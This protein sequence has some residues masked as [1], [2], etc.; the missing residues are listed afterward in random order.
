MVHAQTSSSVSRISDAKFWDDCRPLWSDITT[1][2]IN[3]AIILQH[4]EK[5]GYDAFVEVRSSS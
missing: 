2:D 5:D 1:E 4:E 3:T